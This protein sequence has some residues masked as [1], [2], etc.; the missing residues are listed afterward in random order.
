MKTYTK[1][2]VLIKVRKTALIA[3]ERED[4]E[5]KKEKAERKTREKQEKE[6]LRK[7]RKKYKG[8]KM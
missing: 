3:G 1:N 2:R 5:T 7:K 4:G 6:K 8:E